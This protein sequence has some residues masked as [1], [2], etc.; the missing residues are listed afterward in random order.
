MVFEFLQKKK[1]YKYVKNS[2]IKTERERERKMFVR[3][4]RMIAILLLLQIV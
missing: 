2:E 1:I 3:M 4:T